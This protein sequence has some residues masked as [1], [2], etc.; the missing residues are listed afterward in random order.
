LQS[1]LA[2]EY[3]PLLA[4]MPHVYRD[5]FLHAASAQET[6]A[7]FVADLL[8]INATVNALRAA[9][10]AQTEPL[11]GD[12]QV[13]IVHAS[14]PRWPARVDPILDKL[15]EQSKSDSLHTLLSSRTQETTI[16][17]ADHL[18]TN[19]PEVV[20]NVLH[21]IVGVIGDVNAMN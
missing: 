19:E 20:L 4:E 8:R 9:I 2:A 16:L 15:A 12:L 1:T 21:V 3:A 13:Q 14:S 18:F 5:A 11:L 17:K 10:Q 6:W 7:S